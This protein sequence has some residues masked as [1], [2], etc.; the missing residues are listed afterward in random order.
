MVRSG[1]LNEPPIAYL[2]VRNRGLYRSTPVKD[3]DRLM[4]TIVPPTT[5]T[6]LPEPYY[7]DDFV[8]LYHN[9]RIMAAIWNDGGV[10]HA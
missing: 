1:K 7:S 9:G 3:G 5:P 10:A 6:Q 2:A 4:A 8:T